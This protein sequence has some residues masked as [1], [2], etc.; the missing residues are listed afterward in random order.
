MAQK[1]SMF[2]S[3]VD[4]N[5]KIAGFFCGESMIEKLSLNEALFNAVS[6]WG[7]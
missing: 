1:L 3:I 4:F 2:L 7:V 5:V 6:D